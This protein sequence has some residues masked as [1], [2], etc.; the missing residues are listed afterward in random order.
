MNTIPWVGEL[1]DT[2]RGTVEV[3]E[4]RPYSHI[5]INGGGVTVSID[6]PKVFNDNVRTWL[7]KKVNDNNVRM[8]AG[9]GYDPVTRMTYP[10]SHISIKEDTLTIDVKDWGFRMEC[11]DGVIDFV[12]KDKNAT[13]R[14][15]KSVNLFMDIWNGHVS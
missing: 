2:M 14:L 11:I 7:K 10:D 4:D 5:N 1:K 9:I 12:F 8:S 13:I 3:I 15:R 6:Y